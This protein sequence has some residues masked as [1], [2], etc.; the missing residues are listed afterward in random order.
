[1]PHTFELPTVTVIPI[2]VSAENPIPKP[3][4]GTRANYIVWKTQHQQHIYV[5]LFT[6]YMYVLNLN[7]SVF[8]APPIN[9]NK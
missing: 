3:W 1:M 6:M 7:V 8:F 9:N 2:L 5:N 4:Q